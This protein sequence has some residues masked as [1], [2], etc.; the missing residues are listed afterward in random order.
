[1]LEFNKYWRVT[2]GPLQK[3]QSRKQKVE[4]VED[5]RSSF[6]FLPS[7]KN[8]TK[9]L[10][11][12]IDRIS[13]LPLGTA[14]PRHSTP[15]D[16]LLSDL[17]LS[18]FPP[19]RLAVPHPK[20]PTTSLLFFLALGGRLLLFRLTT[21]HHARPHVLRPRSQFLVSLDQPAQ[22][23]VCPLNSLAR[24]IFS[25]QA[26]PSAVLQGK[27]AFSESGVVG[28]KAWVGQCRSVTLG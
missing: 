8:R 1:M 12:Q 22:V 2:D 25:R 17:I 6:A 24:N 26:W 11:H 5:S 27:G 10:G 16:Y 28:S 19:T 4:S 21:H 9:L 20:S 18:L 15:T 14:P 7:D 23:L 3:Q 13:G